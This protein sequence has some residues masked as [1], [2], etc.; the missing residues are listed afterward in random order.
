MRV[1]S[2]SGAR[3]SPRTWA[4]SGARARPST[5][6][7]PP[8]PLCPTPAL[9]PTRRIWL[10][11]RRQR[12]AA[13][14][15]HPARVSLPTASLRRRYIQPRLETAM[16]ELSLAAYGVPP[17]PLHYVGRTAA[18]SAGALPGPCGGRVPGQREFAGHKRR[19]RARSHGVHGH[20]RAG[21]QGAGGC[22]AEG[23]RAAGGCMP[24]TPPGPAAGGPWGACTPQRAMLGRTGGDRG[25]LLSACL[26]LLAAWPV[27]VAVEESAR[28]PCVC[29]SA[30]TERTALRAPLHV[31]LVI[32]ME[33][34]VLRS[35]RSASNMGIGVIVATRLHMYSVQEVPAGSAPG[36]SWCRCM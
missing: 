30:T 34:L 11:C 14:C 20:P 2:W 16:R 4:R 13:K 22:R 35:C 9:C 19:A 3:R 36:A 24:V 32:E 31:L 18:A 29:A 10:P 15:P 28:C 27:S 26:S 8:L 5:S 1:R 25:T 12:R 17:R 21:D 33:A 7:P 6:A 23:W